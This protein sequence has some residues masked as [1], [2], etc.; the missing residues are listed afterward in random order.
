MFRL[1]VVPFV[2]EVRRPSLASQGSELTEG[3]EKKRTRKK[4]QSSNLKARVLWMTAFLNR[5]VWL[6]LKQ[7]G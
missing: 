1:E 7:R 2:T 3:E 5:W 4:I 6:V